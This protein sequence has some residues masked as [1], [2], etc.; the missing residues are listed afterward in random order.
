MDG[1]YSD[2]WRYGAAF[3][4]GLLPGA[5]FASSSRVGDI[6]IASTSPASGGE[7]AITYQWYYSS[8]VPSGGTYGS[9]VT[10]GTG[11][12]LSD[13]NPNVSGG[14]YYYTR[15]AT[16]SVG[17]Q[18]AVTTNVLV[19]FARSWNIDHYALFRR[20]SYIK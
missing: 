2:I 8:S 18:A 16:D 1:F 14:S 7:G 20:K 19:E 5:I 12:A 11:V 9:L 6:Q 10:G 4:W 17:R 13:G 15:V 3:D